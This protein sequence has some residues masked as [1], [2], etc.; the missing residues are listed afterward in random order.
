MTGKKTG[1]GMSRHEAGGKYSDQEPLLYGGEE[2]H[3]EGADAPFRWMSTAEGIRIHQ[4][5]EQAGT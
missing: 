1:R 5:L 4:F 3:G 2:D